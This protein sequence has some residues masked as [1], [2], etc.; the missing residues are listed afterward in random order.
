MIVLKVEEGT[1]SNF[2]HA[3]YMVLCIRVKNKSQTFEVDARTDF[4]LTWSASRSIFEFL[5]FYGVVLAPANG[6]LF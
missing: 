3:S 4:V 6:A 5:F 1:F 2:L